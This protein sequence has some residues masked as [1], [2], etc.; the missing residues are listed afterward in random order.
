MDQP[1]GSEVSRAERLIRTHCSI[2]WPAGRRCL[3]CHNTFPC[4][5]YVWAYDVLI[6]AGWSEEEI[7]KLDARTGPWS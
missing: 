3:N 6:A 1:A 7:M 5:S 4:P 2:E